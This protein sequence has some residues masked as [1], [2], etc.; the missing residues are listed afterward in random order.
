M[1]FGLA[2]TLWR[3]GMNTAEIAKAMT[4]REHVVYNDLTTIRFIASIDEALQ[5]EA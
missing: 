2:A 5:Q 4:V 3:K 1:N